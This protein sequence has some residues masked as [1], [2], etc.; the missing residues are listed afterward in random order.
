MKYKISDTEFY[1]EDPENISYLYMPVAN[2]RIMSCITPDGHGDNK[3]SQDCFLLEP[4]S[5]EN[6][7]SS[8]VT[9]NFWCVMENGRLWSALGYSAEQLYKKK[10]K[11]SLTAGPYWQE[12][13]RENQELQIVSS[14][15]SFCPQGEERAEIMRVTLENRGDEP[16]NLTPVAAVPIYG[17]GADHLRDHRHVTSLLNRMEIK[18]E[19]ILVTPSMAFDERGHH[20]NQISYGVFAKD[21]YGAKPVGCIPFTEDFIGEGGSLIEPKSL[22]AKEQ[23][24]KKTGY[25]C[26]GY[27]AIGALWFEK[28]SL[29]PG[30]KHSYILVL[31]Y[32]EEGLSYLNK[33]REEEAF[34]KMKEY[35]RD[36]R[37][38]TCHTARK[39]F[40][41]FIS[42]TS[43]QPHLRRIYGCSFLPYH[44]YG[45]GGRGWRDLW[46][47]CLSIILMDPL[48][49]RENLGNFFRGVRIDGTNATII[50]KNP[51]EF[52]ADRNSIVRVWM[53]HG[54]W[55]FR[56]VSLYLEQTG[57]YEFL[58]EKKPYFRDRILSRGERLEE[59]Q[60]ERDNVLS[61]RKGEIYQGTV[62]EHL[63][64]QNL[65][66]F[67]DVGEHNHMKLHG[68]D[69]NDALDMASQRGESVAF[70]A[71]YSGNFKELAQ[72]FGTMEEK[73]I[74]KLRIF[75]ELKGLLTEENV[76]Y[77]DPGK[78]QEIL[79][80]YCN[81]CQ[82]RISGDTEEIETRI[83]QRIFR[84]MGDWI[85]SH[86]RRTEVTGDQ[87]GGLWFNGYYDN[88]GRKAE[89]VKN[90]GEEGIC[91]KHVNGNKTGF[92]L[93]SRYQEWAESG[94]IKFFGVSLPARGF[95]ECRT[96]YEQGV[97]AREKAFVRGMDFCIYDEEKAES[98]K[99]TEDPFAEQFVSQFSTSGR[100]GGIKKLLN[101]CFKARHG[102]TEP[103]KILE[104][105][106]QILKKL[107]E[108][109]K[110]LV[111]N[112]KLLSYEDPLLWDTLEE[113]EEYLK[114]WMICLE[115]GIMEQFLCD[116][117]KRK[118]QEA[119]EYIREN[120]RK[121]LNM[122]M[123]SNYV[124]MNY[125]LFSIAFKNY[126][127]I[128][129]V[130]YLK[131]IRI[132]EAKRL[133]ED[134]DLKIQEI[135]KMVGYDND[136]HFMKI[137][138]SICGISPSEYRKNAG[139]SKNRE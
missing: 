73:G 113:Y 138:K 81:S 36:Q 17:R 93:Q 35:W 126:T 19:G 135:G 12:I 119:V 78:K 74:H 34:E 114:E 85:S 98:D 72:L 106:R 107:T 65:A 42:W 39:T 133:L 117:N 18:E 10:E 9:R 7:H 41:S 101:L 121:D 24:L 75:K 90:G 136:K 116:Q 82:P 16:L 44:D 46:Q 66:Q 61:T 110:N 59:D 70:T 49:V 31:S 120:Y 58:L 32:M 29:L 27:E 80:D 104:I 130:N 43:L 128:N 64:L 103:E 38:I 122:A 134:T 6:L 55:C 115:N 86:I 45:R 71:A 84:N 123:V 51:G 47:D 37:L 30:E 2:E 77:E 28:I 131:A 57:D 25:R 8:M 97:K 129:F 127:G 40:D 125:S 109:Y 14:V 3:I 48:S 92:I 63:M 76:I 100:E 96:A 11:S 99:K 5:A 21:E 60:W 132:K 139:I 87:K 52:I 118:I 54:Y 95:K 69:W 91:I 83:L 102:E 89:G 137:F 68:A 23:D 33:D 79:R 108:T 62:I 105:I 67:Y 53:D 22:G 4:V 26:E 56:T 94:Q 124:S 1:L 15:R 13:K 88:L 20:K 50:G 112:K 111:S